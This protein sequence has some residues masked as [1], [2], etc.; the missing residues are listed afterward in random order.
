VCANILFDRFLFVYFWLF[1]LFLATCGLF[2]VEVSGGYSLA[3]VRG[4]LIAVASLAWRTGSRAM[5]FSSCGMR[6]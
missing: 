2:L 4:L 3:A 6:A 5:G 1:W